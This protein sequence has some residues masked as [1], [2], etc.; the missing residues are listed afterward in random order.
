[1]GLLCI[2]G[3][4]SALC[5]F[6]APQFVGASPIVGYTVICSLAN[7]AAS[8]IGAT[9]SSSPITVTGL[10]TGVLYNC[11]ATA[12]NAQGTSVASQGAFVIATSSTARQGSTDAN[13][14]GK[15]E[16]VVRTSTG[17]SY[18]GTL[19]NQNKLVFTNSPD[20]GT[21]W[22]ILGTGDFS[23]SGRSDL[24]MQETSTGTVKVW[25]GFEGPPDGEFIL[26]TVKPGWV[27][28]AITDIDGDGK[29]DIIWRFYSTPA[30]PSPN[31]DD[32]GVVF[33]WFMNGTQV[34]Q[35]A[36]R[37]GAPVSW[38]YIGAADLHGNGR[39]DMIWVSPAGAIRCITAL[40]N[41]AYVNELIG[42]LP[43]GYSLIKTG[44]FDGDGKADLLFRDAAGHVKLSTMNG[45]QLRTE[46]N[47]PD[48]SASWSLYALGDLNGDGTMD[49]VWLLPDGSLTLWLMSHNTPATPT[50]ISNAGNAPAGASAIGK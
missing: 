47:L 13:G 3:I 39:G 14:D 2:G 11:T 34:D 46:Y 20:P 45:I 7:G 41:R 29:A 42:N 36:A 1:M 32:N 4:G 38:Q 40:P 18:S 43:T 24:L 30:N 19:N 25:R 5:S 12:T 48:T 49:I 37:G 16:V 9:G 10:A 35:V 27:V 8:G 50:V 31:P 15:A 23:G 22:T 17:N 33:V 26:R 6:S 28:A 44:D 21:G